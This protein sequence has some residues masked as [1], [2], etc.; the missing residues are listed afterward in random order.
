MT[1][2]IIIFGSSSTIAKNFIKNFKNKKNLILVS[3]K[4]K[5]GTQFPNFDYSDENFLLLKKKI[6]IKKISHIINFCGYFSPKSSKKISEFINFI[7]AKNIFKFAISNFKKRKIRI[8]TI[9]SM[10]SVN[11]NTHDINYSLYKSLT[12][13]LI[14]NLQ[15][16]YKKSN[17]QFDDLQLG[18][19]NTKMRKKKMDGLNTTEVSKLISFLIDI[20]HSTTFLP[21]KMFPKKKNYIEY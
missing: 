1:G 14:K 2:K 4:K 12:S 18:A 11:A 9:T 15:L 8:I 19:I 10:D 21:I 17:L 13:K 16:K 20:N 5:S 6:N 7:V 3:S